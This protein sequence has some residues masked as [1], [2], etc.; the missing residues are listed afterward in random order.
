MKRFTI[1]ALLLSFALSY[2]HAY[3]ERNI[4]CNSATPEQVKESLVMGQK[5]VKY[6]A[7]T[8]RAGWDAI[9]GQYK[10]HYIKA[11]ENLLDFEWKV[12]RATDYLAFERSGNRSVMEGR[13]YNNVGTLGALF[14]AEMAEGKGRFIDPMIDGI[15]LMCEMTSWSAT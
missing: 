4:F 8:D 15:F 2:A 5:W 12:V 10:D 7:Y 13:Y 3:E 1:I 14:L 11:G 6:P 9:F